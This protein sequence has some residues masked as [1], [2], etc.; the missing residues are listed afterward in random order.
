MSA[1]RISLRLTAAIAAFV[2]ALM[3]AP[4]AS[5]DYPARTIKILV[6]TA[7]GGL[8]DILPRIFGQKITEMTGQPVVVETRLGGNGAVAGE[9]VVKS[10]ADGYTL[11]MG[12]HGV[13]AM[14]PH[15]TSKLAFD[16]NKDFVPV[17]H[18]MT[19]PNI[20]VVNPSVPATS[21]QELIALA[22]ANPGKLTFAS[23][24]VGSTGHIAGELLKQIAGIEIVHVPYRGA[25]QAAQDV[26]GGQVTMMFDVVTLAREPVKAGRMRALGV[27]AKERVAALDDVPT[28]AEAGLPGLEMSA[29]FGLIAPT[30]T[31]PAVIAWL[32][33][34][35]NKVFSAPDIRD[36]FV[37]QGA[38]LPLGTPE[39][40]GAHIAA[41]Y[42]RWGP[43]I[44]RAGIRID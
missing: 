28:L 44:T 30:G 18:I 6:S 15:L 42:R 35:A 14:L 17:V 38:L 23:Q 27:A 10:P 16:P 7:P 22:K 36:R 25:P 29:W 37:A 9:A 1:Q 31:P 21:L 19:V 12:F 8:L 5:Q 2:A 13:N 26:M 43:V 41:E 24:G 33:R 34:E 4:A 40:F 20:L 3:P 32:N 11:M 39:A